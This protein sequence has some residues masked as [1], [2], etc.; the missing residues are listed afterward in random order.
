MSRARLWAIVAC[1]SFSHGSATAQQIEQPAAVQPPD[2]LRVS[3]GPAL[4]MVVGPNGT[5]DGQAVQGNRPRSLPLP[6]AVVRAD[7]PV[8]RFVLLGV[9]STAFYWNTHSDE[10][11]G[12]TGHLTFDVSTLVRARIGFG[13]Y[14]RHEI[15]LSVPFGPSFDSFDIGPRRF[16]GK[17]D[18]EV[19]W[20][21]GAFAGYQF[22]RGRSF[23]GLF[24]EVGLI[25]H[26]LPKTIE[27]QSSTE[28]LVFEPQHLF[29]RAG[30]ILLPFR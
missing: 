2:S 7:V 3:L 25:H 21:A 11:F 4:G 30:L 6:T 12:D 19:G 15:V 5:V 20:H 1:I 28:K 14:H 9:Q 17:L 8:G 22:I 10:N 23:W 29:I 27:Y 13:S 24:G 18:N 26:R 16:G